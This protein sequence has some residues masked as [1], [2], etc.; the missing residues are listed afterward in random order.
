MRAQIN[1]TPRER[2]GVAVLYV[3]A[4]SAF[5]S[6]SL[7]WLALGGVV[8]TCAL[9]E[10]RRALWRW[11]P[12]TWLL[13]L[14]AL[15]V[16]LRAARASLECPEHAGLLWITA[17]DWCKLLLCVPLA[18]L[19]DGRP[20]RAARV[21]LLALVGLVLGMLWH[22]DWRLLAHAPLEFLGSREQYEFTAI[23]AALYAG[24]GLLGLLLMRPH[25]LAPAPALP[26]RALLWGLAT[27]LLAVALVQSQSRGSWVAWIPAA[28][29]GVWL[30]AV[31][32]AQR[33]RAPSQRQLWSAA[34]LGALVLI[35]VLWQA[36]DLF[37]RLRA[38]LAWASGVSTETAESSLGQRWNAQRVGLELWLQRPWFGWGPG[39]SQVLME[40]SGNVH[41]RDVE[42]V[43]LRHLHNSYLEL[44]VQFGLVGL[45]LAGAIIA[46][47]L[48]GVWRRLGDLSNPQAR[49]LAVLML[50]L[51]ANLLL[52]GLTNYRAVHHDWLMAWL[53]VA[54]VS[55]GL[56]SH[57]PSHSSRVGSKSAVSTADKAIAS[58][59]SAPS[60][61]PS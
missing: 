16:L 30:M 11:R 32:R 46:V 22:L 13:V 54:G 52:W 20:G 10:P 2:P 58:P 7:S 12:V 5:L 24:S 27:L 61:G 34:V 28:V 23:A 17:L 44:L 26:L 31:V 51:W 36:D 50:A 47:M 41:V 42:G 55:L 1:S 57:R 43:T 9:E 38:D 4:A 19:I 56:A 40:A 18:L 33:W 37:T 60:R 25:L 6:T 48:Q 35:G 53:V 45:L 49:E 59:E 21:L 39:L 3:L 15:L 14:F 29:L 8:L